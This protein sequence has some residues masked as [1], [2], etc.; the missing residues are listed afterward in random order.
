MTRR[1][2]AVCILVMF[3][4]LSTGELVAQDNGAQPD[5]SSEAK[6]ETVN[7][8][9]EK[10]GGES[11]QKKETEDSGNGKQV[12][13]TETKAKG[14]MDIKASH[15]LALLTAAISATVVGK[16]LQL[17][18]K[19]EVEKL[20]AKTEGLQAKHQGEL[21]GRD[22]EIRELKS[23]SDNLQSKHQAD[24]E[25]LSAKIEG[26]QQIHQAELEKLEAQNI[27]A[28]TE[29]KSAHQNEISEHKTQIERLKAEVK[30]WKRQSLKSLR[31]TIEESED[32]IEYLDNLLHQAN[33]K[34]E[35]RNRII[36]E[37]DCII[38]KL[39]RETQSQTF[40]TGVRIRGAKE[41][42]QRLIEYMEKTLGNPAELKD[43]T[44]RTQAGFSSL[45]NVGYN[46]SENP[47][48]REYG[49]LLKRERCQLIKLLREGVKLKAIISPSFNPLTRNDQRLQKRLCKLIKFLENQPDE[50]LNLCQIVITSRREASNLFF[51]GKDT[52]FEGHK[53]GIE[54]G[55]GLTIM[56]QN[57]EYISSRLS[58]FDEL[59]DS[60]YIHTFDTF[61]PEYSP[62]NNPEVLEQ[63]DVLRQTVIKA[64]KIA[65]SGETPEWKPYSPPY[66]NHDEN[67]V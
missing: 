67:H 11:A 48:M 18:H 29:N 46:E 36:E 51:L 12:L 66:R 55:Y 41:R 47:N 35:Q 45:S 44:I 58:I 30:D 49:E 37:R 42:T 9:K 25:K 10:G 13:K 57:P 14:F 23:K 60:A 6:Q 65:K 19:A 33:L 63:P 54:S 56:Y 8:G 27:T 34:N 64:L 21:N 5:V 4:L 20:N 50:I 16:L 53:T 43:L 52:L 22:S 40:L 1:N 62:R 17:K 24:V 61:A 28:Q 2:I 38:E 7:Q 31:K 26:L 32:N 39:R 3:V 15:L 59:F